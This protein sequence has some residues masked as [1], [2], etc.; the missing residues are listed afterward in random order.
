MVASDQRAHQ[1]RLRP[2]ASVGAHSSPGRPPETPDR[3]WNIPQARETPETPA[4][5][6]QCLFPGKDGDE[7]EGPSFE[8]FQQGLTNMFS[9]VTPREP[10]AMH[11]GMQEVTV[12]GADRMSASSL[13]V[14]FALLETSRVPGLRRPATP[15]RA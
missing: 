3:R 15:H 9:T 11:Y 12:L 1:L 14:C 5:D 8:E 7:H 10:S 2:R 6:R 4:L 13:V